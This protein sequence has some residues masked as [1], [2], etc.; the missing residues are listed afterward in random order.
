MAVNERVQPAPPGQDFLHGCV[1]ARTL[2]DIKRERPDEIRFHLRRGAM[3]SRHHAPALG[4]EFVDQSPPQTASS[5]SD[6]DDARS[7]GGQGRVQREAGRMAHWPSIIEALTS[8]AWWS[9]AS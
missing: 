7:G 2:R 1:D 3:K 6:E 8:P 9:T 4:G 5:A